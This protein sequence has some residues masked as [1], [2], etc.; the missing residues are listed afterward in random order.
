MDLKSFISKINSTLDDFER[1][2]REYELQKQAAFAEKFSSASDKFINGYGTDFHCSDEQFSRFLQALSIDKI[3]SV[4]SLDKKRFCMKI[5][6]SKD[7]NKIYKTTLSGCTCSDFIT[8]KVPC[9]HMYRL[10]LELNII[11]SSWDI[12]GIPKDLK[13][14]IDSLVYPDLSD[15]LFLLHNNPGCGL[16][17]VKSGIDIS[18]FSELGLLRLA[19]SETDY[20]RILDKH[21]SRGDLFTSLSTYR[22]PIDIEL[23]S[24]TTKLAM[25]SYLVH[26]LPDLSRRLCRKYRYVSYP[27]TVYDNRELILRYSDRYIID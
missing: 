26:K 22:Y 3:G 23:N 2:G 11:T 15:F 12:S 20:F 8:R 1:S 17:R 10:A 9:K 25:L 14:A 21:Y 7:I 13:S 18:L 5:R 4:F 19:Q 16:F 6:S 24:S 27:T